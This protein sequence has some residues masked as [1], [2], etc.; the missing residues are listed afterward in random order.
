M[1]YTPY[2][3]K[4]SQTSKVQY[5]SPLTVVVD[6][7]FILSN[8]RKLTVGSPYLYLEGS[9]IT[10]VKLLDVWDA[11]KYV[12]VKIQDL[13]TGTITILKGSSDYSGDNCL[14]SLAS[15]DYVQSLTN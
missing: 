15:L 6:L 8:E 14:W 3:D 2:C 9:H 7:P 12:H 11:D 1:P 13:T 5:I 4:P 10:A